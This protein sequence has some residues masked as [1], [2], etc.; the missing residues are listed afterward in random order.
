MFLHEKEGYKEK[1]NYKRKKEGKEENNTQCDVIQRATDISYCNYFQYQKGI[2]GYCLV[3]VNNMLVPWNAF[4]MVDN[5]Y[6]TG[7]SIIGDIIHRRVPMRPC[8]KQNS[9]EFP[10]YGDVQ[11]ICNHHVPYN[12]ISNNI[13]N[14]YLYRKTVNTAINRLNNV[15]VSLNGVGTGYGKIPHIRYRQNHLHMSQEFDDAIANIANDPRNL[16]YS[17]YHSG[18]GRGTLVDFPLTAFPHNPI[19]DPILNGYEAALTAHNI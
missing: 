6:M 9:G 5:Y 15:I 7:N 16:F 1:N 13:I 11:N 10:A 18:D 4:L 2:H 14:N 8:E 12:R 17:S 19:Q 3:R